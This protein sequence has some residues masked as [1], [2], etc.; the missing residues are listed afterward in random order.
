MRFRIV[1]EITNIRDVI[2]DPVWSLKFHSNESHELLHIISGRVELTY[3]NGTSYI[4]ESGDT[5]FNVAGTEHKDVFGMDEELDIFYVSFNWEHDEDFFTKVDNHS[6]KTISSETSAEMKR[7]FDSMRYDPGCSEMDR[8]VS[9]GRLMTILLLIYRDI[10]SPVQK[11]NSSNESKHRNLIL[12]AKNYI[13]R[14]F[15][16]AISLEDAADHLQVSPF[17]LSRIFSRESDF[18][19]V[20][21]LTEVRIAEAKKLLLDG[22]YIVAEVARMVGYEDPNYFS[23]VFK[24]RVGCSPGKYH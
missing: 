6:F 9:C 3:R 17:Y 4:A 12:K 5:L 15:M 8:I 19:F 10:T 20:E 23:R 14:S 7:L 18:S 11:S 24:R 13:N 2:F 21:Y 1:P 22:G 16:K